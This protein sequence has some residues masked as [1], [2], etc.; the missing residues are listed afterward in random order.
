MQATRHLH[1][2]RRLDTASFHRGADVESGCYSVWTDLLE[3]HR[4]TT[5]LLVAEKLLCQP[6]LFET[7]IVLLLNGYL[8]QG[9]PLLCMTAVPDRVQGCRVII[10][11][12]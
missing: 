6:L 2:H 4:Y 9:W 11:V 5:R 12:G 8:W 10:W 3:L 7:V 1:D